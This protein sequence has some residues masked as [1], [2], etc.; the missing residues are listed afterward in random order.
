VITTQANALLAPLHDRMPVILPAGSWEAWLDPD[1]RDVEALAA[2]LVPAPADGWLAYPVDPRVNQARH[3][4][5]GNVE[6]LFDA[7]P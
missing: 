5:P 7:A 3:D 1:R 4:E 2:L 6:P